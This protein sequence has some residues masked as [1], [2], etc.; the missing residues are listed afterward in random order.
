[1]SADDRAIL[2]EILPGCPATEI[3][4][5]WATTAPDGRKVTAIGGRVYGLGWSG[6]SADEAA[7][8]VRGLL[9]AWAD[10]VLGGQRDLVRCTNLLPAGAT[11]TLADGT[12]WSRPET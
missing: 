3:T 10:A 9:D 2:V 5:G 4:G 11:I 1:M 8:H 12:V 6:M 7:E